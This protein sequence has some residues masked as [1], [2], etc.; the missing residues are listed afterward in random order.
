MASL[1]DIRK[2]V[3]SVKNTQQITKAMKMVAASKLRRA[4]D[5]VVS[6]GPYARALEGMMQDLATRTEPGS[7]LHP[8]L[9]VRPIETV[10]IVLLTSDRGLAGGFNSNVCR[11]AWKLALSCQGKQVIFTTIGK[12][13]ADFLRQRARSTRRDVS[14]LWTSLNYGTA[15]ALAKELSQ[16]Y[17]DGEVDAVY[18]VHNAF[19][20]VIS[21]VPTTT[22]LLPIEAKAKADVEVTG[23]YL[24]EPS[25]QGVLE[26][27]V[28]KA[29]TVKL[30]RALAE[31]FAAEHAARM[32]SME[33]ATKNAGDMIDRLTLFYNRTRQAQITRELVEIVSGAQALEG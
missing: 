29:I 10:E 3:R 16:R 17:L 15:D 1:R 8:L 21:Q 20:S 23:D 12:K 19:A 24:Y 5:R 4:H 7:L 30:F 6:A 26:A 25:A 11:R 22:T 33:S 32:T 31:S 28:P 18:L 27:L 14:S 13:G 2:R 9:E